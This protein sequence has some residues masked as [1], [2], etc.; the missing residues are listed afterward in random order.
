M[1]FK[2]QLSSALQKK[3][4]EEQQTKQRQTAIE[5]QREIENKK[6]SKQ[7]KLR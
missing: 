7:L 5:N 1:S 2:E 4:L 3:A 6:K